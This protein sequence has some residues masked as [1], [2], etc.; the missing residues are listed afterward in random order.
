MVLT[1]NYFVVKCKSTCLY[2]FITIIIPMGLFRKQRMGAGS[3]ARNAAKRP[4]RWRRAIAVF[5]LF[6]FALPGISLAD[7]PTFKGAVKRPALRQGYLDQMQRG[8][9]KCSGKLIYDHDGRMYAKACAKKIRELE[10]NGYAGIAKEKKGGLKNAGNYCNGGDLA[11]VNADIVDIGDGKRHDVFVCPGLFSYS[12]DFIQSVIG[13]HEERHACDIMN[14]LHTGGKR[15]TFNELKDASQRALS[16]VL[17][18]RAF[19]DELRGAGN[20]RCDFNSKEYM[21]YLTYR[22]LF[23]SEAA[24]PQSDEAYREFD[25]LPE[26]MVKGI[27]KRFADK[28]TAADTSLFLIR[29][30]LLEYAQV[31]EK[32]LKNLKARN[33]S[34]ACRTHKNKADIKD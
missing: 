29:S 8:R 23:L 1:M 17:E 30:S 21:F 16:L 5:A 12:E 3:K 27:R 18:L 14:G 24:P 6:A 9:E 33:F 11:R 2:N 22:E 7:P 20:G 10:K 25:K 15:F 26:E 32:V 28:A 13:I 31:F 4:R 34:E 19:G